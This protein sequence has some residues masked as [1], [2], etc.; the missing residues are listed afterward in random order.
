MDSCE[1]T[2]SSAVQMG[3][4]VRE[5]RVVKGPERCLVWTA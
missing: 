3:D 4:V 1:G 5:N 2:W